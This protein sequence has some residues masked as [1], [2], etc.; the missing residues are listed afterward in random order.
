MSV[1]TIKEAL[2]KID[3][4]IKI[5]GKLVKALRFADDQPVAA[6]SQKMVT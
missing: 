4:G 6:S 1:I 2:E 5:D 3:E